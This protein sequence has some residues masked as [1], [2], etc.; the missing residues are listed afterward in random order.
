M[1]G[2]QPNPIVKAF[3]VCDQIIH[4]ARTGKK[5]VIGIF[6]ELRAERLPAVHPTL[7]IYANLTDGRGRYQFEIRL[8]DAEN[9]LLGSGVPPPIDIPTPL[10]TI[11]LAAELR[12]VELPGVGMYVFELRANGDVVATKSFKV[13]QVKPPGSDDSGPESAE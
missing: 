2:S 5:S 3:L 7:W 1:S 12:N 4:D 11:E 13:M 10:Q 9:K 8:M 6:H